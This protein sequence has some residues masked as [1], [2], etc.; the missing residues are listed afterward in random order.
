MFGHA[1][2]HDKSYENIVRS[3]LDYQ[4]FF[5]IGG[6]TTMYWGIGCDKGAPII[7]SAKNFDKK[8]GL[9]CFDCNKEDESLDADRWATCRLR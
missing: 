9:Y 6:K 1:T 5:C 4:Q 3:P 2:N 8:W 7:V